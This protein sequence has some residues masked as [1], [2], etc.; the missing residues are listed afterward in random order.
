MLLLL[1]ALAI[2]DDSDEPRLPLPP[3]KFHSHRHHHHH[4]GPSFRLL[5][6]ERNFDAAK[7]AVVDVGICGA[8]PLLETH[9]SYCSE[10]EDDTE[11]I[12]CIKRSLSSNIGGSSH[13]KVLLRQLLGVILLSAAA[14]FSDTDRQREMGDSQLEAWDY[15]G[16]TLTDVVAVD[17]RSGIARLMGVG[18]ASTAKSQLYTKLAMETVGCLADI[19]KAAATAGATAATDVGQAVGKAALKGGAGSKG[20]F[21]L[22]MTLAQEVAQRNGWNADSTWHIKGAVELQTAALKETEELLAKLPDTPSR[23]TQIA[24]KQIL[25]VLTLFKTYFAHSGTKTLNSGTKHEK[26][27]EG[28]VVKEEGGTTFTRQLELGRVKRGSLM[29]KLT[30]YSAHE[31]VE[32]VEAMM[33]ELERL[34][35]LLTQAIQREQVRLQLAAAKAAEKVEWG[36]FQTAPQNLI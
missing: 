22:V 35:T 21:G 4:L 8:I 9:A 24:V 15:L 2:P 30:S 12:L 6:L 31:E 5:E 19:G 36:E 1:L 16:T 32:L 23:S 29:S 25:C 17:M 34:Y 20:C 10:K 27:I 28:D 13:E 11:R 7:T 14:P 33:G 26:K 18:G 3:P